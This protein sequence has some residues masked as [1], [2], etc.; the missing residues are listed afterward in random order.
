MPASVLKLVNFYFQG[1]I[2]LHYGSNIKTFKK[3]F[4]INLVQIFFS[5]VFKS[6]PC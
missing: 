4:K 1:N 2:L 6:T 3:S 5:S